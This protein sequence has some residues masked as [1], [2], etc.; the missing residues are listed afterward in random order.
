MLDVL[1]FYGSLAGAG[2]IMAFIVRA[3]VRWI[4]G[5]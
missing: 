5:E 1:E 4:A 3:L 2:F